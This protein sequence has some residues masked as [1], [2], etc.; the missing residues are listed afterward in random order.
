MDAGKTTSA[1]CLRRARTSS[2]FGVAPRVPEI[3]DVDPVRGREGRPPLS[4]SP[5]ETASAGS[6]GEEE[7]TTAK[8]EGSPTPTP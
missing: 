4:N 8:L 6:P 3:V 2:A 1:R 5:A 7:F